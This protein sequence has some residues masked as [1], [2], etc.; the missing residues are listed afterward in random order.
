MSKEDLEK[1]LAQAKGSLASIEALELPHPDSKPELDWLN[2]NFANL[3]AG[4]QARVLDLV[5]S[6]RTKSENV[7]TWQTL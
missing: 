6:L 7:T 4:E 5:A 2:E 3:D 1:E